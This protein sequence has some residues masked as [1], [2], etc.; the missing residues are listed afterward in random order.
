MNQD[1]LGV[2][3]GLDD[4]PQ[5]RDIYIRS[6]FGYPGNKQASLQHILPR[7]PLREKYIEVFGGSGSVLA[8]RDISP[9]E[10][11]NDRFA[12]VVAFYRCIADYKK[13]NALAERLELFL[14]AREEFIWCRNTWKNCEDDVERAAR[15]YYMHQMSFGN[16]GRSFG[17][18]LKGKEQRIKRI[19]ENI[20]NF[21]HFHMRF[22]KV[23]IEN[24]DWRQCFNDFDD[25]NSVFFCDPTYLDTNPH[26]YELELSR[27]DHIE[28]LNRIFACQGF[29]AITH[30]DHPLYAERQWDA[31]YKWN[32]NCSMLGLAFTEENHL[33]G[34]EHLQRSDATEVLW[35]KEA[36]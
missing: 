7:L 9:F 12:G 14:H 17:R 8:A 18:A 16:Q 19:T 30:Y 6:P 4:T 11:F 29:V 31:V 22:K 3:M 13:M 33:K 35:I 26:I 32:V 28:L 2:L 23:L 34:H 25:K 1:L 21:H 20:P 36:K 27:A 5:S 24:L 10:V 15:W